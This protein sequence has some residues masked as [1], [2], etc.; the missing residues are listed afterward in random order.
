M[1]GLAAYRTVESS[2]CQHQAPRAARHRGLPSHPWIRRVGVL[3]RQKRVISTEQDDRRV[4]V[5]AARCSLCAPSRR[6]GSMVVLSVFVRA[7]PLH[8]RAA[9]RALAD[10]RRLTARVDFGR[11]RAAGR[12]APRSP[13]LRGHVP[14]VP[15]DRCT[16]RQAWR[17]GW[18]GGQRM[19]RFA[20]IR[21]DGRWPGWHA[22]GCRGGRGPWCS[23]S[24]PGGGEYRHR[25]RQQA[26]RR[27]ACFA[28]ILS[29]ICP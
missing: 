26:V 22:R 16:P 23:P 24:R 13:V 20:A 19:G 9:V 14:A 25:P 28:Q 6:S 8:G 5:T 15:D 21:V 17:T 1:A 18:R 29:A 3:T 27:T 10:R 2:R 12:Q 4:P 11:S 7:V